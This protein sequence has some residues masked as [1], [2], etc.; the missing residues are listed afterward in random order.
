MTYDQ[1]VFQKHTTPHRSSVANENSVSYPITGAGTFDLTPSLSLEHTLF[2]PALSNNL[3]YVPQVTEQLN[4]LV[5]I[6]QL[7]LSSS[8]YHHPGDHWS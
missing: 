5:L 6:Y 2:V 4:C 3:L 8:R 7:F 1:S